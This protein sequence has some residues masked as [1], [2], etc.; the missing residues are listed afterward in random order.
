VMAAILRK[1]ESHLSELE[2]IEFCEPRL[3]RFALPRFLEF[4]TELPR[5]EN[6]K[7]QKFKLRERGI[8]AGTWDRE[9]AQA[10]PPGS[11]SRK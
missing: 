3:P 6:G 7:V 8:G 1:P 2:L 10:P 9:K 5:T 4:V 11:P